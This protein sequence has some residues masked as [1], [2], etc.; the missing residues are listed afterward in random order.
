MKIF[1]ALSVCIIIGLFGAVCA[2]Q[3]SS[4][5]GGNSHEAAAA[6][7]NQTSAKIDPAKEADIRKLLDVA[8]T[9]GMMVQM[10][11]EMTK[12]IRPMLTN[13]FPPGEY[14]DRLIDLFFEKFQ[15]N[16][17]PQKLVDLAI[18]VYDK[19]LTDED[20]RGL[21]QFYSTPLG[22]KAITTMP[23]LMAECSEAGRKWGEELGRNSIQEVLFE[24]PDLKEAM[25]QAAK[26]AP[27]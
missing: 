24:H 26:Q 23:K 4:R 12:N 8:G 13:M 21:L 2:A 14:R 5:S 3:T 18:P 25:E 20:V 6:T 11:G 19:Y 10:M 15:S 9:K 27:R 7:P 17:D 1:R 16:A 22:Q